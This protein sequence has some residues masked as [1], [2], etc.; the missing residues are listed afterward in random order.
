M[1]LHGVQAR[2]YSPV[3]LLGLPS[4]V[5][6]WPAQLCITPPV[7]R[8]WHL[9]LQP[10]SQS[11]WLWFAWGR[12]WQHKQ[13]QGPYKSH[14]PAAPSREPQTCG[15]SHWVEWNIT[16]FLVHNKI[17]GRPHSLMFPSWTRSEVL[18]LGK[19]PHQPIELLVWRGWKSQN[20]SKGRGDP[21]IISLS[22]LRYLLSTSQWGVGKTVHLEKRI[23]CFWVSLSLTIL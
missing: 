14:K 17:R 4:S 3:L 5:K 15:H 11:L 10:L 9:E 18:A 8:L 16:G 22:I 19:W 6:W 20:G 21:G 7:C 23:R 2:P 12:R 1:H 13:K